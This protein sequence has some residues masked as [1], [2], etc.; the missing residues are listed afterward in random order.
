MRIMFFSVAALL[1]APALA[2]GAPSSFNGPFVGVQG[3]WQQD[4]QTLEFTTGGLTTRGSERADGL[5][6]GGQ[7]GYDF[8]LGQTV[9]GI[10]AS[11]TGRTGAGFLDD[12]ADT[13]RLTQ[14]RTVGTTARL[15]FLVG[16]DALIYGRGGYTNTQYRLEDGPFRASENR[17]GWTVGAGYEQMF[18]R[19]VSARLE[20][21]YADYGK[22]VLFAGQG[23][24]S[25]LQYRRHGVTAG[26]NFR[27]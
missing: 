19:N 25:E 11:M 15:G 8:R 13:Y 2:Q 5:L 1:A 22:D 17:D 27:F 23:T 3:G 21:N 26:L 9:F 14:G 6:Y 10:E 20:Y 12:G 7:V 4:R 16:P 18:S 24:P